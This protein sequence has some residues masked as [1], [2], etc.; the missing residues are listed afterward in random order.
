MSTPLQNTDALI[1]W[2][3]EQAILVDERY[4]GSGMCQCSTERIIEHSNNSK[5]MRSFMMI[6]VFI[7]QVAFTH[8][9]DIYDQFQARYRFPKLFSHTGGGMARPSW[10]VYSHHGYDKKMDWDN[11]RP[12]ALQLFNDCLD[13]LAT[14]TGDPGA[15]WRFLGITETEIKQDFEP[16]AAQRFLEI[17]SGAGSL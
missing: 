3:W 11:A 4:E 6:S 13:Y 8:F 7:D 17:S 10:L 5:Q 16:K 2:F 15:R 9:Q 14:E 12:I 1:Q